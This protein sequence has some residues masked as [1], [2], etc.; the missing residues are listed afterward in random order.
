[1]EIVLL[2]RQEYEV[3]EL[4]YRCCCCGGGCILLCWEGLAA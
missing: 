3:E 4:I 2:V 1:M